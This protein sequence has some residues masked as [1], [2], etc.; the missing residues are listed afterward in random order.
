MENEVDSIK[1]ERLISRLEELTKDGWIIWEAIN[2][3]YNK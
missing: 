1:L 3:K 2:N